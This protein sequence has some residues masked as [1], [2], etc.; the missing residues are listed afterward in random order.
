MRTCT[1][2]GT[3][4]FLLYIMEVLIVA[5]LYILLGEAFF[6][7]FSHAR[8]PLTANPSFYGKAV[9]LQVNI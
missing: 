4:R 6:Q 9:C 7:W 1:I 2:A 8:S 5:T 3:D